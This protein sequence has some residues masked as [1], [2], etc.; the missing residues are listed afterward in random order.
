MPFDPISWALGFALSK[1][2][3]KG[4]DAAFPHSLREALEDEVE[5]WARSASR[6]GELYP[7]ALFLPTRELDENEAVGPGL[8]T[9]RERLLALEVPS[10]DEWFAALRERWLSVRTQYAPDVQPFFLAPESE[11]TSLLRDLAV[12]LRRRASQDT[13]VAL[14]HVVSAL[15]RIE[16]TLNEVLQLKALKTLPPRPLRDDAAKRVTD[17]ARRVA[18]RRNWGSSVQLTRERDEGSEFVLIFVTDT[19]PPVVE[20][21]F[22]IDDVRVSLWSALDDQV[23]EA[24]VAGAMFGIQLFASIEDNWNSMVHFVGNT[25]R[26]LYPDSV[27]GGYF[28]ISARYDLKRIGVPGPVGWQADLTDTRIVTMKLGNEADVPF[29]TFGPETL[30]ELIGPSHAEAGAVVARWLAAEWGPPKWLSQ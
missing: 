19:T 26:H 16:V 11:V 27:R 17:A 8:A 10:E 14:P 5:A 7:Q 23:L 29:L 12:R 4:L 18:M 25:S 15:D 21:M 28:G 22:D 30:A 24:A 6:V 2:A 13:K 1:A 3:Q 20:G 9:L